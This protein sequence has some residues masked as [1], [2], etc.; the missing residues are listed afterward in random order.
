MYNRKTSILS[1]RPPPSE[2][3]LE[4][5]GGPMINYTDG[6][7]QKDIDNMRKLAE[8]RRFMDDLSV[9][10]APTRKKML[11]KKK[12]GVFVLDGNDPGTP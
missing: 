10:V 1:V 9:P 3:K 12:V 5:D 8:N 4:Y 7:L 11:F 6:I 2:I